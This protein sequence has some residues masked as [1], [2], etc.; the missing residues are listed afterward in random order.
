MRVGF[1]QSK[2]SLRIIASAA[3][4]CVI[5]GCEHRGIV[6]KWRMSGSDATVWEFS[7]NGAVLVGDAR[8][9]YKLGDQDRIKIETPFA[10]TVYQLTIS[11]DQMVLQ[12]PGGTKLEF[13]RIKDVQR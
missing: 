1:S 12:E 4:L 11:G 9:R 7:S 13:T 3:L 6:G 5:V 10:T 2:S 8:G